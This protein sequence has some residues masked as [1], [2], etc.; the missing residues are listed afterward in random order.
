MKGLK[1]A[2]SLAFA[3]SSAAHWMT[4]GCGG[5][6]SAPEPSASSDE[7]IINGTPSNADTTNGWVLIG[8]QGAACTGTLLQNDL[9]ITA[10]H[11]TT[12]DGTI[13]GKQHNLVAA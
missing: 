4:M 13:D 7:R 8:H 9:V 12:F 11:C 2:T 5:G 10:K 6:A 3:C 1:R